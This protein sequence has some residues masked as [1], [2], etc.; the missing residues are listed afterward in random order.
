MKSTKNSTRERLLQAA[1]T[2]SAEKGFEQFTVKQV[3]EYAEVSEALIYKYFV[4]RSGLIKACI[5]FVQQR[6]RRRL[7]D[8]LPYIASAEN[9]KSWFHVW[10][11]Y[12]DMLIENNENTVF[13]F[14][15]ITSR[16]SDNN[17]LA[18]ID[19]SFSSEPAI[20]NL[21]SQCIDMDDREFRVFREVLRTAALNYAIGVVWGRIQDSEASR[22]AVWDTFRHPIGEMQ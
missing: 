3:A 7:A 2:V 13:S 16:N 20:V 17:E 14:E 21:R 19:R 10:S 12:I 22:R 1:V 9:R 18:E 5:L 6:Y 4:S 15:Y 11:R 8:L